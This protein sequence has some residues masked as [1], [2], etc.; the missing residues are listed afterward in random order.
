MSFFRPYIATVAIGVVTIVLLNTLVDPLRFFTDH[1]IAGFDKQERFRS[2]GLLRNKD[3][4]AILLGSSMAKNYVIADINRLFKSTS[5]LLPISGGT[6]Y[7]QAT[8]ARLALATGK[9]KL[10]IWEIYDEILI[11]GVEETREGAGFPLYMYDDNSLNDIFYVFNFNTTLASLKAIA[12]WLKGKRHRPDE[13]QTIEY[14]AHKYRFG[15]PEVMQLQLVNGGLP[16]GKED[17]ARAIEDSMRNIDSNLL[18][19]VRANPE[20]EFKLFSP[21]VSY[22]YQALQ[23]QRQPN[24]FRAMVAAKMYAY[25]ELSKE[26]NVTLYDFAS[27]S[28]ITKDFAHYRDLMHFSGELSQQLLKRMASDQ[29]RLA[30]NWRQRLTQHNRELSRYPIKQELAKC[31]SAS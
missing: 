13:W 28:S 14:T 21:P 7:E 26:T 10:V 19:V 18:A 3:Y 2:A 8:M 29:N 20:V 25:E 1:S 22:P 4:D 12:D 15:C 24:K 23:Q 6:L 30:S 5:L 11:A 9:P 31:L 17:R 27:A 16:N